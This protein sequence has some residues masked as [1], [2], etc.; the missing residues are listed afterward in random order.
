MAEKKLIDLYPYRL[1]N[2]KP[3]YLLLKRS[4]DR[5]YHG[6][7]RMIGGKVQSG[8][9]YWQAALR[10]L[11]EETGLFP[12]LLWVIPSVNCFYEAKTDQIHSIPA[13]AAQISV[14]STVTLDGEHSEYQWFPIKKAIK[15][16]LWPE[17]VRLLQLTDQLLTSNQ[18]PDDWL[19]SIH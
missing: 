7:W 5:I 12:D 14:N 16:I 8:E 18:I 6:Q 2:H 17:Q 4:A 19:V 11:K 13:F 10:E 15:M 3:E 1:T 9:F